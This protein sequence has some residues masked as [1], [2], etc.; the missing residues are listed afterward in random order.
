MEERLGIA[1]SGAIA[2]GLAAT[3]AQHGDV[4]LWARSD[5]LGGARARRRREV[6]RQARARSRSPTA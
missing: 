1:G 4:L 5:E 2:C 6:V 3:A